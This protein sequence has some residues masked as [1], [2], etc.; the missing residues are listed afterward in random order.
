MSA[1][2]KSIWGGEGMLKVENLDLYYGAAQT[3]RKVS[4]EARPGR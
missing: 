4:L 1:S 2:S 3:L